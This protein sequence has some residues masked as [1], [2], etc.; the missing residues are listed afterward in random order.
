MKVYS[1][2]RGGPNRL[3]NLWKYGAVLDHGEIVIIEE[4]GSD[5]CFG[6]Y[7]PI[8]NYETCNVADDCREVTYAEQ[9]RK[10]T[11]FIPPFQGTVVI[12]EEKP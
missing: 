4:E 12:T 10:K 6:R 8:C 5:D 7:G 3:Y 11:A 1:T 9:W 2:P